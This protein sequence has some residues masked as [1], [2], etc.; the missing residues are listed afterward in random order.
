MGDGV[1][2]LGRTPHDRH[3]VAEARIDLLGHHVGDASG[4]RGWRRE[5]DVPALDVGPSLGTTRVVEDRDQGLH[6]ERVLATD[7]D[8]TKQRDM[9]D[10]RGCHGPSL[11]HKNPGLGGR[12]FKVSLARLA[13][14]LYGVSREQSEPDADS[15]TVPIAAPMHS[16][17]QT[18]QIVS[19]RVLSLD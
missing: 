9:P 2:L 8:A 12:P 19:D 10:G 16:H 7:V 18:A 6:R 14:R 4:Q 1:E 3:L 11:R 5:D 17:A 13:C 15:L